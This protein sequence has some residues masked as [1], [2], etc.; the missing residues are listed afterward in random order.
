MDLANYKIFTINCQSISANDKKIQLQRLIKNHRPEVIGL[1]ETWLKPSKKLLLSGYNVYRRDGQTV[2]GGVALLTKPKIEVK[3]VLLP[4]FNTF[5]CVAVQ[6]LYNDGTNSTIVSTYKPPR[7][8]FD[9]NEWNQMLDTL[10]VNQRLIVCGDFNCKNVDWGCTITTPNGADSMGWA[11][12]HDLKICSSSQPSRGNENLDL[13]L[14]SDNID[15]STDRCHLESLPFPSDHSVVVL[16][17]S[18]SS[19]VLAKIKTIQNW[20]NAD[21]KEFPNKL[22][23]K[24]VDPPIWEDRNMNP[25]EI[26]IAVSYLTANFAATSDE[27]IRTRICSNKFEENIAPSTS[28]LIIKLREDRSLLHHLKRRDANGCHNAAI[29]QLNC[30]IKNLAII[31]KQLVAMNRKSEFVKRCKSIRPGPDMFKELKKVT[32]Y[33]QRDS[34]PVVL[35]QDGVKCIDRGEQTEVMATMFENIHIEARDKLDQE[36]RMRIDQEMH[37]KFGNHLPFM[38]FSEQAPACL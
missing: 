9:L 5:E 14:C 37:N 35:E 23:D 13:Y 34:I 38:T 7:N 32:K 24:L 11:N 22:D 4:R 28:D 19:C 25:E 29:A 8:N 33:K 18:M 16:R 26:E 3:P 12:S 27:C 36:R 2:G 21:L 17:C 15:I 20:K 6:L 1:N 30:S 31:V 10:P